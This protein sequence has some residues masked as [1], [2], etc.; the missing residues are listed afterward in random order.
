VN[1]LGEGEVDG[2]RGER[3]RGECPAPEAEPWVYEEKGY[4]NE[5]PRGWGVNQ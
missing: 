3:V 2:V 4:E 5:I 1:R